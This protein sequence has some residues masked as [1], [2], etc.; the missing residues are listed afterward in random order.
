MDQYKVNLDVRGKDSKQSSNFRETTS[1]LSFYL[2]GTYYM[3]M[4][5]F[6]SLPFH[7]KDLSH[8]IRQF[9]LVLR[10]FLYSDSFYTLDEYFNYDSI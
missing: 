1:I 10:N 3:G 8:D 5:I 2:R 4:K 9:T 7:L 6:N